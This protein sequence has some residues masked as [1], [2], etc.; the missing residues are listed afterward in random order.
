MKAVL[1]LVVFGWVVPAAILITVYLFTFDPRRPISDFDQSNFVPESVRVVSGESSSR[2]GSTDHFE[3][4]IDSPKGVS[5]FLRDPE[6]EPIR[7][8]SSAI[9]DGKEIRIT[10]APTRDGNRILD[11]TIVA[12]GDSPVPFA[13][14][15]Q[16]EQTKRRVVGITAC[17]FF[18]IGNAMLIV[19]WLDRK[20]A[21]SRR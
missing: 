10:H 9:P 14:M 19:L 21:Q 6:P 5:Y 4:W 17:I 12:T 3:L 20:S 2:T 8:F 11:I 18:V 13:R 1:G 7:E 15:M 16:T